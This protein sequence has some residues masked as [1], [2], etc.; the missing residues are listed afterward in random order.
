MPPEVS[1]LAANLALLEQ[2][3]ELLDGIPD[4][5]FAA[6]SAGVRPIGPH[7]RHVLEHYSCFLDGV[8]A[9]R[10]DYDARPRE[11]ALEA[12]RAAAR[13]RIAELVGGLTALAGADLD[14]A[15]EVRLECG[16]GAED[17]QWS[18]STVRRE[19]HF[20]LS[21]TVHHYAL[22]GLL[23]ERHGLTPGPEF[24]VAPSTLQHWRRQTSCAPQ[25][26]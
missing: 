13:A 18:G 22:I 8:A 1:V 16:V 15:A 10:I 20:L 6:A 23:L 4:A 24:G 9:R 12:S 3:L 11:E 26:G 25:A 2:G 21:H 19:L 14:V 5:V 17:E 7:L